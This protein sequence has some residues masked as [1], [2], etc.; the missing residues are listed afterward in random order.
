M[1]SIAIEKIF[2]YRQ[3]SWIQSHAELKKIKLQNKE[4]EPYAHSTERKTESGNELIKMITTDH[5]PSSVQKKGFV[6]FVKKIV[7]EIITA[8]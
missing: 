7:S 2:E 8:K 5:K 3:N 6:G 4:L 1:Y